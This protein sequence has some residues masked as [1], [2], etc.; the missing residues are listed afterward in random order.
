MKGVLVLRI[1]RSLNENWTFIKQEGSL[2]DILSM[3][4]ETI[5]LPHAWNEPDALKN[6]KAFVKGAFWYKKTIDVFINPEKKYFLEFEGVSHFAN[7]Y[8]NGSLAAHH[9]GGFSTFRVE[10]TDFVKNGE[11]VIAIEV[12]NQK[13][14]TTFSQTADLTFLGGIYRSVTF[15]EIEVTHLRLKHHGG[16][17][18]TVTPTLNEDG[19]ANV[20]MESWIANGEGIFVTYKITDHT[21]RVIA[22]KDA[23]SDDTVLT[24]KVKKPHLWNGVEDPYLYTAT[25]SLM[26]NETCVDTVSTRFGIRSY[27]IDAEKGFLLNGKPYELHSTAHSDTHL[28]LGWSATADD[29]INTMNKL[30]EAGINTIQLTHYQHYQYFY[31]L[32]D[33]CGMIVWSEIPFASLFGNSEETHE[34]TI[35]QM[36]ELVIQ[37]YNHPSICFWSI[38]NEIDID[39]DKHPKFLECLKDLHSMINTLDPTRPTAIINTETP[40]VNGD[41]IQTR[42]A[43]A[44]ELFQSVFR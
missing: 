22:V 1:K 15:I 7:V 18:F 42:D 36:T 29:H 12:D 26:V 11:N 38:F 14:D 39:H 6:G 30:K 27:E 10:I 5:Q 17:G 21:G 40:S 20:R 9:Q 44:C 41:S 8:V 28:D 16:L 24:L 25:A 19:T 2:E 43:L 13:K 34:G 3:T 4:G 23:P 33:E 31:D 32:C 35:S 37:N